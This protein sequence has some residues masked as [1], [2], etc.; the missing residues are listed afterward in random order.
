MFNLTKLALLWEWVG[1]LK[2][3]VALL[4][5]E[6]G[7]TGENLLPSRSSATTGQILKL[8]GETKTPSW[9]DEYSYTPPAYSE[10]EV[11]TGQKWIDGKEIY[12]ISYNGK[13]TTIEASGNIEIGTVPMFENIINAFAFKATSSKAYQMS[14]YTALIPGASLSLSS[15]S[16]TFSNGYYN[17]VV[18]YT[19]SDPTPGRAPEDSDQEPEAEEKKTTKKKSSK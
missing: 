16:P 19:K 14:S 10:T 18:Y 2:N 12:S 1:E 4:F 15:I 9:A 8:T 7:P 3:N 13:F 5:S 17:M 11:N 6:V